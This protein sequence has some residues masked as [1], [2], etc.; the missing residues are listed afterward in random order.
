MDNDKNQIIDGFG[1]P[2]NEQILEQMKSAHEAVLKAEKAEINLI[3]KML[4]HLKERDS[5]EAYSKY[6]KEAWPKIEK[7]KKAMSLYK[8]LYITSLSMVEMSEFTQRTLSSMDNAI[9]EYDKL[10]QLLRDVPSID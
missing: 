5:I 1:Q 9:D 2:L 8:G 7:L 4:R 3:Y 10:T 6:V